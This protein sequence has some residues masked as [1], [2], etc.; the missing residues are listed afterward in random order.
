M[1]P[2]FG[3]L[4]AGAFAFSAP[5]YA[6]ETI[7]IT[8]ASSH[9]LA[10]PW[11]GMMKT[12]FMAETDRILAEGGN[13]KI[14][15][16]EAFGGTLYKANATLSSVEQGITDIGWVFSY[17]E[18]AKLPL[19]QV[20][21][22]TPF[23]TNNAPVMLETMRELYDTNK[24]FRDEWENHNV[25]LLGMTGSDPYDIFTKK[26]INKIEDLQGLKLSVAGPLANWL[27]GTGANAVDGALTT[28]YTDIQTG[29]SDGTLVLAL[30][31]LP[32]KLYEV[33]PYITRVNLG[34]VYSGGVA[35]NKDTWEGLP[36]DVQKAMT[37]AGDFYS[38]AHAQDMVDRHEFA[39]K[40]IVELGAGQTP[41]VT[42]AELAPAERE[43]WVNG[44]PDLAGDWVKEMN[45]RGLHGE[46]F[47][48]AYMDGLR[49]RGETPVRDWGKAQ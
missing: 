31:V 16:N 38:K 48:K 25:K 7:D 45:S 32:A 49:T 33:A 8:I 46:T 44:L 20:T 34:V 23:A 30:G 35:I 3:L 11:V 28:F 40:K 39:M 41:P 6:L 43:R 21:A 47:L 37:A 27:R 18:A 12:K 1:K 13:F 26:P 2:L 19:S 14:N 4:A 29:V 15:W 5:V 10:I 24:E 42:L 22:Y 17:L 9:P 36:P